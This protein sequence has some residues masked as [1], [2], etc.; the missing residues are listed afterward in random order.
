MGD[1]RNGQRSKDGRTLPAE[2]TGAVV[3]GV[4]LHGKDVSRG[5]AG[6][7]ALT[8]AADFVLSVFAET[9]SNGDVSARRIA[10]TKLRDGPTGWSCE[11][12]LR[13]F[14]IGIDDEGLDIVSAFVEAKPDTAGFIRSGRTQQKKKPI[15]ES[16][17]AFNKALEEAQEQ[18]GID[19]IIP[20]KGTVRTVQVADVRAS[21][22]RHYQPKGGSR[23]NA[24]AE[25]QAF[26]RAL[27]GILEEG[28]VKQESWEGREWLWRRDE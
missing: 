11:F 14:K 25:R 16:L 26:T 8:A 24:D 2:K 13:P 6:S 4:H 9:D 19:R 28:T 22:A 1:G 27:K 23:K 21:F 7:Y 12:G 18:S 5:A 3:V 10:L 20:G 17:T 15:P